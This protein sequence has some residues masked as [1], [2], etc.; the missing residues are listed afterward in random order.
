MGDH[1]LVFFFKFRMMVEDYITFGR[2]DIYVNSPAT[3]S[4]N[5]CGPEVKM[6]IL[7]TT[8]TGHF[9]NRNSIR[10]TYGTPEYLQSLGVRL[11][12]AF[13]RPESAA[14]QVIS[15]LCEQNSF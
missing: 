7:I 2:M 13:G 3:L 1:K 14:L 12:F 9:E 6:L 15:R 10:K 5:Y 4:R 11:L 8:A